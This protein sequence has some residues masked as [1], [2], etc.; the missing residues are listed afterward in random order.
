MATGRREAKA[1][2]RREA[3]AAGKKGERQRAFESEGPE[4]KIQSLRAGLQDPLF[5]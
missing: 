5:S 1:A 2:V 4:D 3:K